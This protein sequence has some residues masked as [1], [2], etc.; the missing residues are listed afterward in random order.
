MSHKIF[1]KD[2]WK[3]GRI[4]YPELKGYL[5][6]YQDPKQADQIIKVQ[7]QLDETKLVMAYNQDSLYSYDSCI[8]ILWLF[9][10]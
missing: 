6:K 10:E 4:N 9:L 2:S 5:I 7:E 3:T 8:T 1:P